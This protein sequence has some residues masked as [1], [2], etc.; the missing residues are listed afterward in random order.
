[1]DQY[2]DK[3]RTRLAEIRSAA[4]VPHSQISM[5]VLYFLP[6]RFLR[7]YGDM[8]TRALKADGGEDARARSQAEA[9]EVGKAT[10]GSTATGRRYKKSF[11]VLDEKALDL[12]T[13]ID[14]R[15]RAAAREIEATLSGGSVQ[16]QEARCPSC[17]SF[18]QARWKFCP[19]EG[20]R[21]TFD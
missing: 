11:V 13:Q 3:V 19:M 6:E 14:K 10:G 15:L 17:G 12:K 16:K 1:M 21:L 18:V 9:G 8:F 7:A 4:G 2:D 5:E 20:A